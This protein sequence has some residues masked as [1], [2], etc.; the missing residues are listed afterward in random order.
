VADGEY[1]VFVEVKTRSARD[2]YSPVLGI[3]RRKQQRVR[4]LALRYIERTFGG[5]PPP[6]QPRFD[7]LL[8]VLGREPQ[9]EH[10]TNAF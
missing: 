1:L 10:L 2:A 9:I 4:D 5:A 8:V 7:V 6:L 3:T